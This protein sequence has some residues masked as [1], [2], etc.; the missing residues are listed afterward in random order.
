[1]IL[2]A[3]GFDHYGDDETQMLDGPYA[4]VVSTLSTTRA[5]TGIRSLLIGSSNGNGFRRVW[6]AAKSTVG[7]GAAFWNDALPDSNRQRVIFGFNDN[8]NHAQV[9]FWLTSTGAIQATTDINNTTIIGTS[10]AL[11]TAAAWNH[12]E[13]WVHIHASAGW[14]EVR[15]NGV[16][17]LN[18]VGQNT[19]PNV[20]GETSQVFCGALATYFDNVYVDDVIAADDAGPQNNTFVGDRKVLTHVP[21]AD[22]AEVAWTPSAGAAR[23]AMI[24]EIPADADATYDTTSTPGDRMG[25]TF[26]ALP[27]DISAVVAVILVHKS[28]KTDAGDCNVTVHA[29]SGGDE[30]D[31]ND[32]AIT[33]QYTYYHDVFEVDPHT[34]A[35]FTNAAASA[36]SM[37]IERTA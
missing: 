4:A 11:V 5:R 18:L 21:V 24:D 16:T 33:T 35:P 32:R 1:M 34:A 25:V 9:R 10:T 2:W 31:G 22:T 14:V 27:A 6:G 28:R 8:S 36:V 29:G 23:Y 37:V 12:I 26:A 15:L 19:D 30:A 17:I 20:T 13:A 7:I 3:D